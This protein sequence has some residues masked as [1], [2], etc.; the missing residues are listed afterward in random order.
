M[1]SEQQ[2]LQQTHLAKDRACLELQQWQVRLAKVTL[3]LEQ[4]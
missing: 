2:Q 4:L 1:V 3:A